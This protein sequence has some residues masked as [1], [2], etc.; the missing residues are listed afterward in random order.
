M[1]KIHNCDEEPSYSVLKISLFKK[2]KR[3]KKERKKLPR[4]PVSAL[5]K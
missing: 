3:K 5:Y 4:S 2:E 1:V